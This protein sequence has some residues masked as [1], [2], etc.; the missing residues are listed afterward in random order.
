MVKVCAQ[1]SMTVSG[2]LIAGLVLSTCTPL[3]NGTLSPFLHFLSPVS[4][5]EK[6]LSVR[7]SCQLMQKARS[8]VP[9]LPRTPHILRPHH[10]RFQSVEG[11]HHSSSLISLNNK[12]LK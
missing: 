1:F 9:G 5:R 11:L 7:I 8:R 10:R 12:L 6:T 3:E 2:T 4:K